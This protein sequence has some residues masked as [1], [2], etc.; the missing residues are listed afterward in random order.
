MT[1]KTKFKTVTELRKG[2]KAFYLDSDTGELT[3]IP[4]P[5]LGISEEGEIRPIILDLDSKFKD[6]K[7]LPW[8]IG[9]Q[10][11]DEMFGEKL[12]K[13]KLYVMAQRLHND[14]DGL[15]FQQIYEIVSQQEGIYELAENEVKAL[16]DS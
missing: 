1:E 2:W 12:Y 9:V 3:S 11:P 7:K 10:R 6:A 4:V 5:L 15:D 8:Y 13:Q 14:Y 16:C